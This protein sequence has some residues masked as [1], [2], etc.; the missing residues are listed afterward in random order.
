PEYKRTIYHEK[1]G[2]HLTSTYTMRDVSSAERVY[3]WVA[4]FKMWEANPLVGYGPGNFYNFYKGYTVTAFKTYVSDNPEKS[5]VHNYFL[6]LLVE[7]GIVG[8]LIFL[9]LTVAI[10]LYGESLYHRIPN[11]HDKRW[12]LAILASLTA[13]YV[14][15]MLSDMIETDKVGSIFFINIGMLIVLLH[16]YPAL[17]KTGGQQRDVVVE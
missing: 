8:F 12:V 7:Q 16:K 6:L 14:S 13:I 3:R 2:D 17:E 1:L 9:V 10:F 15:N 11:K 4:G 5:T